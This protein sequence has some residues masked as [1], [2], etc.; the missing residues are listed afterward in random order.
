M[1]R[2]AS[3]IPGR[4][5]II[6]SAALCSTLASD[7]FDTSLTQSPAKTAAVL[8]TPPSTGNHINTAHNIVDGNEGRLWTETVHANPFLKARFAALT[9]E[10]IGNEAG[11]FPKTE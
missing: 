8:L 10:A 11:F 5:A 6:E 9:H 4:R 3:R 2:S 1:V 7:L